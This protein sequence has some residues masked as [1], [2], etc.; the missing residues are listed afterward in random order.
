MGCD[1]MPRLGKISF[2]CCLYKPLPFL[3]KT[4]SQKTPQ[5]FFLFTFST[6]S[7]LMDSFTFNTLSVFTKPPPLPH[8]PRAYRP[9]AL[10]PWHIALAHVF[11]GISPSCTSCTSSSAYRSHERCPHACCPRARLPWHI[12]LVHVVYVVLGISPS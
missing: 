3:V 7:C 11:L 5:E 10:H 1:E 6:H 12:V 2:L 4:L 8:R 9:H